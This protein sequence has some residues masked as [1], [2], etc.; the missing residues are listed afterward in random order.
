MA[1]HL[2][3]RDVPD[4]IY[5]TLRER[6]RR[7]GQSLRRYTIDVLSAH[8]ALP[9]LDEWLAGLDELPR[10]EPAT[11]AAEAVREARAEDEADLARAH[12]RP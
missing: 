3:V 1:T 10:H 12:D 4:P 8:C 7:H 5:E 11:R 9:T 2:H 6:A